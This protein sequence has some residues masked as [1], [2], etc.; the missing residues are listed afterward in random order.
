MLQ[1]PLSQARKAGERLYHFHG[2]MRLRHNKKISCETPVEKMPLATRYFVPLQL[3]G[4]EAEPMVTEGQKVLKGDLLGCFT[5]PGN[6]IWPRP[7][8]AAAIDGDQSLHAG[9]A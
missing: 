7:D 1:D 5:P 4:R 2:G 8:V 9:T 6:W 3:A